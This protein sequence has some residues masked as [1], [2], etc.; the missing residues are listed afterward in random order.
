MLHFEFI[1]ADT[2]M[3]MIIKGSNS[4]SC[5]SKDYEL[6]TK[7][8]DCFSLTKYKHLC[9]QGRKCISTKLRFVIL[10]FIDFI[11]TITKEEKEEERR[12]ERVSLIRVS[13]YT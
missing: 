4:Q 6:E 10:S 5:I 7:E 9:N 11:H 13:T 3:A 1:K 12:G 8:D 2:M